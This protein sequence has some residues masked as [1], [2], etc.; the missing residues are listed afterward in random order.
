MS[1]TLRKEV[2]KFKHAFSTIQEK[3]TI[4]GEYQNKW[5]LSKWQYFP[6]I[7][8]Y[9]PNADSSPVGLIILVYLVNMWAKYHGN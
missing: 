9:L 3:N 7:L 8:Q 1:L 5:I 6:I 2:A 4:Y